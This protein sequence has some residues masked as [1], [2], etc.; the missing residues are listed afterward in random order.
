MTTLHQQLSTISLGKPEDIP[1]IVRL[2]ENPQSFIALPGA[3][4][5]YNHDCLHVLLERKTTPEDEAF[6][7]GFCMG[8]DPATKPIHRLIFSFFAKYIYPQDYRFNFQHFIDFNLGFDYGKSFKDIQFNLIDFSRYADNSVDK[9]QKH[10]G[11]SPEALKLIRL[12]RQATLKIRQS[13]NKPLKV[14]NYYKWSSSFFALLGGG[15]LALN[16]S[17]SAYGFIFLAM[18]SSQLLV[19]SLLIKDKTMIVYSA[20]V[21]FGVDL[22][23]VYRWLVN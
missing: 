22:L 23:G 18:S 5:L 20:S 21:F 9:L 10:F 2:L 14:A 11:I 3:I 12:Q 6:I 13:R 8:N 15:L 1:R 7:I 17:L 4:T 16:I 19:A